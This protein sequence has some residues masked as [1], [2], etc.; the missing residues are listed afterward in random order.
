MARACSVDGV[1]AVGGFVGIA[2]F[3][4]GGWV[5]FEFPTV[6]SATENGILIGGENELI[7]A[8]TP[9]LPTPG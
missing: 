3:R 8:G 1:A 7:M 5:G 6:G 9:W 2:L 4:A